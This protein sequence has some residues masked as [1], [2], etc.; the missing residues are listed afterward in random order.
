MKYV[1]KKMN[2][3]RNDQFYYWGSSHW[4]YELS[5]DG[6]VINQL[7]EYEIGIRLIYD[8]ANL[9]DRFGGLNAK[10]IDLSD[11]EYRTISKEEFWVKWQK[12]R[13]LLCQTIDD[14]TLSIIDLEKMEIDLPISDRLHNALFSTKL[15]DQLQEL[16]MR[17]GPIEE[18]EEAMILNEG[19]DSVVNILQSSIINFPQTLKPEINGVIDFIREGKETGKAI[20][21]WL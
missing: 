17:Y 7:V 9:T 12:R 6:R 10:N 13:P 19:L 21:F 3:C 11:S 4:Y 15:I 14:D 1:R 20:Q 8:M 2:A 18:S 16:P 5:P